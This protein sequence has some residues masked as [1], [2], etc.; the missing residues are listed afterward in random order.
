MKVEIVKEVQRS[1]GLWRFACGD[2]FVLVTVWQR[3]GA[4]SI[5]DPLRRRSFTTFRVRWLIP[6]GLCPAHLNTFDTVEKSQ[7]HANSVIL[8]PLLQLIWRYLLC[9]LTHPMRAMSSLKIKALIVILFLII[10]IITKITRWW[11]ETRFWVEEQQAS[12]TNVFLI[13]DWH[14]CK[15][16]RRHSSALE[17]QG[18]TLYVYR[19]SLKKVCFFEIG[20]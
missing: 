9:S 15:S 16:S 18:Y 5:S 6:R 14:D 4:F 11:P 12:M 3:F 20:T 8:P 1:D 17:I 13:A 10:A 2:V 19:A 7:V